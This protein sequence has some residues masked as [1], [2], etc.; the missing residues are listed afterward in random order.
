M[1]AKIGERP[2]TQTQTQTQKTTSTTTPL[3]GPPP[4]PPDADA[5][6]VG[7]DQLAASSTQKQDAFGAPASGPR[8][9]F[10]PT[11]PK[12]KHDDVDLL[13]DD[14]PPTGAFMSSDDAVAHMGHVPPP[15]APSS[16]FR[17]EADAIA[18]IERDFGVVVTGKF[19]LEELQRVHESL[20]LVPAKDRAALKGVTLEREAVAPSKLQDERG[21]TGT[22]GGAFFNGSEP[23]SD[24]K[25]Y[26]HITFYDAAFPST[27]HEGD[28]RR[29]SQSV[30]LHEAAH[31][32]DG[33]AAG[34]A[35]LA[36]FLA[37]EERKAVDV[38][39]AGLA[40][41]VDRDDAAYRAAAGD[42]PQS[43]AFS[44]ANVAWTAAMKALRVADTASE[45]Q[46]AQAA[47]QKATKARD[48][49]L[50]RL[51]AGEVKNTAQQLV[52]SQ[53][54][55]LPEELKSAGARIKEEA[56]LKTL[57]PLVADPP[58][59]EAQA[60]VDADTNAV[61]AFHKQ[62]PTE[63]SQYGGTKPEENFAEAYALY[64]RDPE[65]LRTISPPAYDYMKKH[66]P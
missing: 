3:T 12:P 52:T 28:D 49:A 44:A 59:A 32:I 26:P 23:E 63:V 64:R 51:P 2:Q 37:Q 1:T 22:V 57:R 39:A 30:V 25:R 56:A 18:A 33:G 65:R 13:L 9:A 62:A 11:K 10:A 46:K 27:T 24:G 4:P 66:H 21:N 50:A 36:F 29:A 48:A 34:R 31:A 40:S 61:A 14:G 41:A 38:V 53:D 19:S 43:H 6:A 35:K 15:R 16:T 8:L 20:A 58:R 55:L 5:D 60:L 54:A 17:T 42:D 47:L 7:I 45:K